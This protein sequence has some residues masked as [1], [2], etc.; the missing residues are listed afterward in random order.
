LL[1]QQVHAV[2]ALQSLIYGLPFGNVAE[3][4]LKRTQDGLRWCDVTVTGRH[5]AHRHLEILYQVK[6]NK[7][8]TK[9]NKKFWEE[10][11]AYFP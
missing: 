8:K 9:H 1:L 10:L 7:L 5:T 11:I 6:D 4:D 2:L 3:M